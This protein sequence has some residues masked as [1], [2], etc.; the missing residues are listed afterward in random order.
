M[1]KFSKQQWKLGKLGKFLGDSCVLYCSSVYK[2]RHTRG[3]GATRECII[4]KKR[5]VNSDKSILYI[6]LSW[7]KRALMNHTVHKHFGEVRPEHPRRLY[8]LEEMR[9]YS[10]SHKVGGSL[11]G[12]QIATITEDLYGIFV[13][14]ELLLVV[15]YQED[16]ANRPEKGPQCGVRGLTKALV[17]PV[18]LFLGS[19]T[20]S[21]MLHYASLLV[22]IEPINQSESYY[23]CFCEKKNLILS[24]KDL[25]FLMQNF[26]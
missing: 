24:K 25:L 9:T 13:T 12:R 8:H 10:C 17:S 16:Y 23:C 15:N 14:G 5:K 1:C 2:N 11:N 4:N 7:N 22:H 19:G 6:C 18:A 20:R 3:H 26:H 21:L